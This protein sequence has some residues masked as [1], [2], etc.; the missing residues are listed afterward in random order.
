MATSEIEKK[1]EAISGHSI[2]LNKLISQLGTNLENG[3]TQED[4][5]QKLE[6]YGTNEIPKPKQS[7]WQVYLAP[8]LNTLIVIYLIMT[9][10]ILVLALVYFIIN[11]KDTSIWITALQWLIIV[12]VNFL[13]AIIQQARAQKKI[14]ALQK[15][16]APEARV[17]R[18][19]KEFEI[20]TEEVV[21]G[22]IIRIAQGDKI[23]ADSR[24]IQSSSL[25]I[26]ES[27]LTGESVPSTKVESGESVFVDDT[28]IGDRKNML[29]NG[30]FATMGSGK[31]LVVNTG[32]NTE[33]GKISLELEELNTGDIPIRQKVNTIGN[34]LA[35]GMMIVFSMLI[36]YQGTVILNLLKDGTYSLE[37]IDK[38]I[39]FI[40]VI[41]FSLSNIIIKAMSVVPI[42]I[43]LLTT[44]I[45]ITGVLAMAKHR[46]IIRNLASIESLGRISVL[47]SDKT[48]TITA[49]QMTVKRVWDATT[50]T[51]YY[52]TGLGYSPKGKI[53]ELKEIKS[54]KVDEK[55]AEKITAASINPDSSLGMLAISGMLNNDSEIIEELVE[56][57]GQYSYS[58]TGSPTESALLSLFN[59]SGID[60]SEVRGEFKLLRE[61]PFDSSLK[62]MSKI[63]QH[64]SNESQN[65]IVFCKGA[66]E[67]LLPRCN[68][69]GYR[70]TNEETLKDPDKD[71]IMKN[72][73]QFASQGFRILSLAYKRMGSLP[74]KGE[75]ER[76]EVETNLSYLGFIAVLDPP[77]DRVGDSVTETIQAGITPIMIT[78]D[79]PLTASFIANNIGMVY[80]KEHQTHEGK[81]AS[82]LNKKDF[83]NTRV[84]ARVAPQ[85]KQVI[86]ERYQQQERVVAM[87]G[88]GVN[89]A[90]ALSMA[91]AGIAM[92]IAG[93]EVSKQ[94]ADL[95]IADDSFNS[96]VTGIREGRALF[97]RIRVIIFFYICINLAEAAC[98]IG[99]S[100]ISGFIP[101]FE[102]MDNIQRAYIFGI[103]HSLP[104]LALI[105]DRIPKDIMDRDPIDSAGIFNKKLALTLLLTSISLAFV[106][107]IV[108][109]ATYF[110][111]IPAS[112]EFLRNFFIPLFQNE[113]PLPNLRPQNW[114]HAKARTYMH[115][116]LYIVIPLIILSIRRIDK[117][118]IMSL[119]EDSYWYTY[120]LAFSVLPIHLILMYVPV[121]QSILTS[122]GLYVDIVGLDMFDWFLCIIGALIP[123]FVLEFVKWV[124]RIRGQ[125][126]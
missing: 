4:A 44:I 58:G 38:Q 65:P 103:A 9:F 75:N 2:E 125:Y 83:I 5:T 74:K 57:T 7:F 76:E 96:I 79:S 17:I 28:P 112:E 41:I 72:I 25:R 115:T 117:S 88:D 42:N 21:P 37:S 52:V 39:E 89:D 61:Y 110:A 22:D 119:K 114:N 3:L 66:T 71:K 50:D 94:A 13:I 124:N 56:V 121:L 113:L 14:E 35:F 111:F 40:G 81:M 1:P 53:V 92:G 123:I 8:L 107:Y 12:G 87:T 77:R 33:F 63:F 82:K 68:Y 102:L 29:F 104:P 36:I 90:L 64:T 27:S 116:I 108:Y 99:A 48:G 85:D 91:D 95:V 109:F 20:S 16:A 59:K 32:G 62:R 45:L 10:L 55:E 67:I 69:I 11:P 60:K 15:L 80:Q 43:P 24:V 98:Y 19:G 46:V 31:A 84:F 26:N 6:E 86:V 23:P 34:Y 73:E 97:Q 49:G 47:C 126:Y 51:H 106:I 118:L 18:E 78:G 54:E 93:T 101:G 100:F 122:I 105:I 70:E 30:T 120:I